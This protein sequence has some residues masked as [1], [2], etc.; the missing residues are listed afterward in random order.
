LTHGSPR[1]DESRSESP[2][3]L[4]VDDYDDGREAIAELL[5][6]IGYRCLQ[7]RDGGEALE[8]IHTAA[9]SLVILDLKLPVASGDEVLQRTALRASPPTFIVMS[10]DAEAA[11]R[12]AYPFVAA[13]FTKGTD[14]EALLSAVRECTR[15]VS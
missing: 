15:P 11:T 9:P 14:P 3:V 12:K 2:L 4:V 1:A 10:G 6:A 13:V 8:L 7:A 5:E